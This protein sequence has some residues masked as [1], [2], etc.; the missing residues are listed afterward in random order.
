[1]TIAAIHCP[2]CGTE[3]PHFP[4]EFVQEQG[5]RFNCAH[6]GIDYLAFP[7]GLTVQ[8]PKAD[9]P[10]A[11]LLEPVVIHGWDAD[12]V[13]ERQAR[14]AD[15][16]GIPVVFRDPLPHGGP[17]PGPEMVLIPSGIYLMG[18]PADE[19][20]RDD[21]EG[22][23]HQVTIARP[24]A[25][26][27]YALTFANWGAVAAVV[28]GYGPADDQGWGSGARPVINVSWEGTQTYLDWLAGL[29]SQDYRLPSES[30][31]EYACRAGTTTRFNTGHIITTSQANF[32]GNYPAEGCPEGKYLRQTAAVGSYLPNPFGLCDMHG[33]IL[34]WVADCWNESY[35]DAPTDGSAWMAGDCGCAVLRGGSWNDSGMGIRSAIRYSGDR[36][37]CDNI[38]SFRVARS[39]TL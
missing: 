34:E 21:D 35:I 4:L 11:A 15:A 27:R 23:Q 33:N 19:P 37:I 8:A 17:G 18:S 32:D 30:E 2:A 31:W 10:R 28:G 39:V 14:Q 20:E 3:Y 5:T 13:Q 29:T 7:S 6:C 22:P 36:G 16:L 1:M 38:V 24:F 9:D 25:I 26:G 12:R